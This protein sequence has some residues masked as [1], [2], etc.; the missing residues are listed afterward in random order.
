MTDEGILSRDILAMDGI[1]TRGSRKVEG[2]E[3][4]TLN[5]FSPTG[6][7]SLHNCVSSTS[8]MII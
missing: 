5:V 4:C 3:K 8:T 1:G 6:S 7:H 2:I